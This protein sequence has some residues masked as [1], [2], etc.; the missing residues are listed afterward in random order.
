MEWNW[1][2]GLVYGLLGGFF[3]FLPVSPAV[4]QS[5]L[6]KIT[7]LPAPGS[8]LS[9]A[10][11]LGALM[12]VLFSCYGRVVKLLHERKLARIAPRARKRQPDVMSL[13]ELRLIKTAVFPVIL[14]SFTGIWLQQ[15]FSRLWVL[16]IVVA[17][18][19]ILVLL[20]HYMGRGNKDARTISPLDAVLVGIGG[21]LG[22]IPGISRVGM[23]NSVASM[24]GIDS[25]FAVDFTYLL[26]IPALA[27]LCIVDLGQLV[28][29]NGGQTAMFLP[30]LFAFLSAFGIGLAGIRLMRYLA[31]KTGYEGLAYY[32]WGLAMLTFIIYLIG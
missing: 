20:P 4:H 3:E 7:D 5:L 30:G 29:G 16:A 31:L 28:M 24:R 9:L 10:V 13:M 15:Y 12:A 21:A 25:S 26:S 14:S 18:N 22:A 2:L 27:T 1:L 17:I 19:G 8:G 23:L 11:H 6:V 32:N